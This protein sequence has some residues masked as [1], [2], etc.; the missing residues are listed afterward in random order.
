MFR[1]KSSS[2]SHASFC[3]AAADGRL[4]GGRAGKGSATEPL[5]FDLTVPNP[6]K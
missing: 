6:C 4:T 2:G 1:F 3:P 5:V